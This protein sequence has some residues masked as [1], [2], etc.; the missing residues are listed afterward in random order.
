MSEKIK[1]YE[2]ELD[3]L[4][5]GAKVENVSY[6]GYE[7]SALQI[8]YV[9]AEVLEALLDLERRIEANAEELSNK[10]RGM[11]HYANIISDKVVHR[12]SINFK[13]AYLNTSNPDTISNKLE[14]MFK[15]W[16]NTVYKNARLRASTEGLSDERSDDVL[17]EARKEVEEGRK[18]LD[19]LLSLY[20][21]PKDG[22]ERGEFEGLSVRV[23]NYRYEKTPIK[24][25]LSFYGEDKASGQS[26]LREE[27][28]NIICFEDKE[29]ELKR[30]D[31]KIEKFLAKA[32]NAFG[33]VYFATKEEE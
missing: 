10:K 32:E 6:P 14:G 25:W 12:K 2:V 15:V 27:V 23:T 5:Q 30:S 9:S 7:V 24:A 28:P 33:N 22:E 11:Y 16:E 8:Y 29:Q 26:Y 1:D 31:I 19:K 20:K 21:P 4:L 18:N 13:R 17:N 3:T